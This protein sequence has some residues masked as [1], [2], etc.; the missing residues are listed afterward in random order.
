MKIHENIK[1]IRKSKGI[2]QVHVAKEIG[3]PYQTYNNYENG[4]RTPTPETLLEIAK[5]L[6]EPI[7]NFFK[8]KIYET[9]NEKQFAV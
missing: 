8:E 5:F 7:E 2:T 4:K 6:N 9:K 1:R 3:I